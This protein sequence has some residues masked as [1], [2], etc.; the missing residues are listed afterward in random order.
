[1]GNSM[2]GA[3]SLLLAARERERVDHLVILDSAGFTMRPGERPFLARLLAS[4]AAGVLADRLPVKRLLTRLFL[5]PPVPGRDADHRRAHR[6]VRGAPSCAPALSRPRRDRSCSPVCRRAT[7]RRP[8][9]IQ[10]K[11]LVVWGRFDPWLPV[12]HADRFV[13]EIKGARKVV[14]E[15]GHLPQEEKPAEVA[16]LIEE[17]SS[18][19]EPAVFVAWPSVSP[20]RHP[21]PP[22]PGKRASIS[23]STPPTSWTG[24]WWARERPSWPTCRAG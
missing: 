13:A 5:A 24:R 18:S 12:S 23:A 4:Q 16:R 21:C 1:M 7:R 15:T 14:L 22:A 2:G 19:H 9:A 8:R 6:R 3:I 17:T 10:A 20:S 11:T